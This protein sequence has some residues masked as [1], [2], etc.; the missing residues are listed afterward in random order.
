MVFSAS[1]ISP[2]SEKSDLVIFVDW[3]KLFCF[4]SIW[5]TYSALR[6]QACHNWEQ[7][8]WVSTSSAWHKIQTKPKDFSLHF[9]NTSDRIE[10]SSLPGSSVLFLATTLS[11]SLAQ[12]LV[13]HG[14][15]A[16][17]MWA[18]FMQPPTAKS[19]IWRVVPHTL[20]QDLLWV[21]FVTLALCSA[22]CWGVSGSQCFHALPASLPWPQHCL[23]PCARKMTALLSRA[24][25]VWPKHWC[26]N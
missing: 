11:W 17:I 10:S 22:S 19:Q 3:N 5:T 4:T 13:T 8:A 16:G 24:I 2:K 26:V 12:T 21:R 1:V 23:E 25:G 6:G 20:V 18:G 15:P 9:L 7:L 14:C